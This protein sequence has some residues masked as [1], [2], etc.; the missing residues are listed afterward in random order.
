M[1]TT[2]KRWLLISI[3]LPF[4]LLPGLALAFGVRSGVSILNGVTTITHGTQTCINVAGGTDELCVTDGEVT[5]TALQEQTTSGIP[6]KRT[7]GA[8]V[9][10]I[11]E[12]SAGGLEVQSSQNVITIGR[13]GQSA[14]FVCNN[15]A[16]TLQNPLSIQNASAL[17]VGAA[18]TFLAVV[19]E[20]SASI[21]GGTVTAHQ[22]AAAPGSIAATG[23]AIGDAAFCAPNAAFDATNCTWQCRVSTAGLI[24]PVYC[25][26]TATNRDCDSTG[27]VWSGFTVR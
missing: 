5:V 14:M 10:F 3:L 9:G 21:N 15:T 11:G 20:G 6:I 16:C 26:I 12:Q 23:S 1:T 25:N 19:Q 18:G 8:Q 22:C 7:D 17:Q 13:S 4:G 27:A 24:T 2:T